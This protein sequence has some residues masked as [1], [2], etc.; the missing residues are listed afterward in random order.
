[1]LKR[2]RTNRWAL[3]HIII[4][5]SSFSSRAVSLLI[6]GSLS[7]LWAGCG[8]EPVLTPRPRAYPRVEFPE[9]S[10]QA[11]DPDYCSFTFQ[12]PTYTRIV[13]DTSFFDGKPA[14]PCWFDIF[15]PQFDARLHF[16][17]AP[18]NSQAELDELRTE[19]FKMVD[20]QNKRANFIEEIR[21][22]KAENNI[23]GMGFDITGPAASPFQF[24]LT[25]NKEHFVRASLYFNTHINP[26]SLAPMYDFVKMDIT[27]LIDTFKW[28]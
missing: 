7:L 12:Y 3:T 2:N 26:D 16:T 28:E 24:Y 1:M 4:V 21:I 13:Q 5:A 15:Y 6:V 23:N 22:S 18:V 8:E 14:H 27:E 20:W 25:D 11:F 9:K 17:Y 10:Y 19:A